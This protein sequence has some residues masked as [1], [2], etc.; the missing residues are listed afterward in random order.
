ML[1]NPAGLGV[2]V[3]IGD[4]SLRRDAAPVQAHSAVLLLL[5]TG[6]G[7]TQLRQPYRT[8]ISARAAAQ[9][10]GIEFSR[11]GRASTRQPGASQALRR[12]PEVFALLFLE[13]PGSLP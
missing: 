8:G 11:H 4:E 12:P 1:G 3:R 5:Y 2:K 13:V 10:D 6:D 9:H 7:L